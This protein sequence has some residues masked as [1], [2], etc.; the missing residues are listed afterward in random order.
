MARR[1]KAGSLCATFRSRH[2]EPALLVL[3]NTS[4]PLQSTASMS[5]KGARTPMTKDA[6]SRIQSASDKSG[7]GGKGSFAARAQSTADKGS[8]T[9]QQGGT[10][11]PSKK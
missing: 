9:A 11:L 10:S 7:T 5:G 8:S 2:S 4:L 3:R 1:S 6:A